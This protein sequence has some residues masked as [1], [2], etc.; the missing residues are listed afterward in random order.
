MLLRYSTLQVQF[1]GISSHN[2]EYFLRVLEI[3][4]ILKGEEFIPVLLTSEVI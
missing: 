4:R 1:L 2:Y 3:H